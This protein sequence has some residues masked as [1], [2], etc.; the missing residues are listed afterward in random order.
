[1]NEPVQDERIVDKIAKLLNLSQSTNQ[2]EA[3]A[4]AARAAELMAKYDIAEA[5][6]RVRNTKSGLDAPEEQIAQADSAGYYKT[7]EVWRGNI[8]TALCYGLGVEYYWDRV[9]MDPEEAKPIIAK[10]KAKFEK[11]NKVAYGWEFDNAVWKATQ[12]VG[13]RFIGKPS[14]TTTAIYMFQFLEREVD[15][16]CKEA[17]AK[18]TQRPLAA[19]ATAWYNA[20]KMGATIEIINRMRAKRAEVMKAAETNP[21]EETSQALVLVKKDALALK[22]Y[23][24]DLKKK[25]GITTTGNSGS[26]KDSGAYHQGKEAGSKINLDGGHR[27]LGRGQLRLKGGD[28]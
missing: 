6:V 20:F 7:I 27:E 22:D 26:V 4:A 9:K 16:L 10:I 23:Y 1:M 19:A 15:R 8:A 17:Y 11:A 3:A 24:K 5:T 25:I 13:V 12:M 21:T 2:H 18:L 14:V 28:S